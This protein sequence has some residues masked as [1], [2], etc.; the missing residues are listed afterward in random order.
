MATRSKEIKVKKRYTYEDYLKTPDDVRY[1]LIEGELLLTPSP[2][3]KHQR[4]LGNIYVKIRQYVEERNMGEVF[5][6]PFDIVLGNENVFEP[7]ILFVS[8]ENS[9]II[10]EAN[11]QGAPDLIIEIL[12]PSTAYRDL[13]K[14]KRI[15]AEFGVKEYWIVDPEEKTVEVYGL[16]NNRFRLR[17]SYSSDGVIASFLLKGLRIPVQEILTS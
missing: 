1:E 2:G 3:A 16:E 11:I 15:Y 12:S 7:D 5:L 14:K 13:V 17:G 10:T 8:K 6:A 4:I 9:G